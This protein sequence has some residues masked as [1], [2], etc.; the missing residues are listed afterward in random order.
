MVN[1]RKIIFCATGRKTA[2][3]KIHIAADMEGITGVV[4]WDEVD[5]KHPDYARFRRLMTGDVNAAI[6]GAFEGGANEVTVSDGHN[7][8][9][10]ILIEE[11]D[12]R[13]RLIS[14]SRS[15]LSMVQG[16]EAGVSGVIFVGYHA[17]VGT[18]NAILEHTWS[19]E[20]V[21]DLWIQGKPTGEIGLNA[22]VC[23]HFEVPVIMISGDQAACAEAMGLIQGILPVEVKRAH[24]RMSAELLP[25]EKTQDMIRE[26]ASRA[27]RNLTLGQASQPLKLSRPI[28]MAI[29]FTQSEMADNAALLPGSRRSGRRI[30]YSAPDTLVLYQA[31]RVAIELA[32]K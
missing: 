11:L 30:E 14:G 3:M 15:P 28:Q 20:R 7:A 24:G 17:R 26:T 25:P 4:N 32:R 19:N 13:A 2:N 9:R 18:Q 6:R 5:P 8:G 16:V 22:A 12:G 1:F 27:V 21:A 23:G 10:N 29:D 31:F